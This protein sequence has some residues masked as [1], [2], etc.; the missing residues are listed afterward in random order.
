[1]RTW[2][3]LLP[4]IVI[5]L[6]LTNGIATADVLYTLT[7]GSTFQ[8]GCVAPCMCPVR[9]PE[10][11]T[12]TFRLIPA[13]FDPLFTNYNLDEIS[14]TAF[15]SNGGIVH[16]IT[17]Q[18]TYKLGGEVALTQQ[19]TLDLSIDGGSSE[20]FDSG[21]IAGGSEFPAISIPSVSNGASCYQVSIDIKASPQQNDSIIANLDNPINGQ[22][23][24]GILPI[25]G[26]ALDPK[27]ITKIELFIDD[28]FIGNIPYGGLRT[29]VKSIYPNYP[30]AENSGFAMIWNYSSL[31]SGDHSVKVRVHNQDD[32]TKDLD[33]LITVT[34]FQG[35]FVEQMKPSDRLLRNNSVTADGIT[36]R[37]DIKI[38][39]SDVLQGFEIIEIIPK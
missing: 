27:G 5:G 22:N 8:E 19:L 14:W 39:W 24:S 12:G 10:V 7:P 25:Y 32:Q 36:K 16:K 34:K 6:I 30:D 1:M 18:G 21:L 26:W 17:G 2:R 11:L 38:E 3:L 15:D 29:D 20:H 23:V 35:E 28:Q 4:S 9:L 31:T 33:A 37:Y 13:G